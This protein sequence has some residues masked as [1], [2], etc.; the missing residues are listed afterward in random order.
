MD[1][2]AMRELGLNGYASLALQAGVW[3]SCGALIGALYFLALHWNARLFAFGRTPLAAMALQLG[4]LAVLAG[5]LTIIVSR[6]GA[7]PLLLATAGILVARTAALRI[8]E[9]P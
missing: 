6:F 1:A 8:G 7:L 2:S 9:Q 3:L 5:A 4:R